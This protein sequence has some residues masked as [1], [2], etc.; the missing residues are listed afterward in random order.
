[1]PTV[2]RHTFVSVSTHQHYSSNTTITF[3]LDRL[4]K[5]IEEKKMI[6]RSEGVSVFSLSHLATQ[7]SGDNQRRKKLN[8][9]KWKL[10][11]SVSAAA[12]HDVADML[13]VRSEGQSVIMVC[14][15]WG[16]RTA[17][18]VYKREE[19]RRGLTSLYI[20]ENSQPPRKG[21]FLWPRLKRR[22]PKPPYVL[23]TARHYTNTQTALSVELPQKDF[24]QNQ[25]K[26]NL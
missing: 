16:R 18:G 2:P 23:I 10:M 3:A 24:Y 8:K 17:I 12:I 25:K 14:I 5:K 19:S 22:K 26:K 4:K 20:T 9:A 6:S 13:S 1:M 11:F 21:H 15:Y 7:K